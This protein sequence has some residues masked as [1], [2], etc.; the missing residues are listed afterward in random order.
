MVMTKKQGRGKNC[1]TGTAHDVIPLTLFP[2]NFFLEKEPKTGAFFSF[3]FP[4]GGLFH[5]PPINP[6]GRIKNSSVHF[7]YS[8]FFSMAIQSSIMMTFFRVRKNP[9]DSKVK[10]AGEN[11][12]NCTALPTATVQ[13]KR[14]GELQLVRVGVGAASAP[15]KKKKNNP[16]K[17]FDRPVNASPFFI[18]IRPRRAIA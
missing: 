6:N 8:Y 18:F 9:R 10:D 14:K 1:K 15:Q 17:I 7:S 16:E 11:I 12:N 3:S 4:R 13:K 5:Q 2:L